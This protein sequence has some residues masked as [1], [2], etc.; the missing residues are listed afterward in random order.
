MKHISSSRLFEIESS[1]DNM[2]KRQ[3][4]LTT[5]VKFLWWHSIMCE[6]AL[7][8]ASPSTHLYVLALVGGGG[9]QSFASPWNLQRL[10]ETSSSE[11]DS[12]RFADGRN[13]I[14]DHQCPFLKK[15]HLTMTAVTLSTPPPLKHLNSWLHTYRVHGYLQE[16]GSTL[17]ISWGKE[18][19]QLANKWGA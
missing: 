13:S 5:F 11:R 18:Q 7:Y 3:D 14:Q 16:I 6:I 19:R 8:Q 9:I 17:H 4:L 2:K 12:N 1:M 10:S 15:L